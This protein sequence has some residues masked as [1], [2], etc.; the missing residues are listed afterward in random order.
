MTYINLSGYAFI[1]LN[2]LEDLK[3]RLKTYCRNLGLK[4]TILLSQEGIN[5]FI[6]G[7]REIVETFNNSLAEFQ[8]P[9]LH[10]KESPSDALPFKRMLVKIKSEIITMGVDHIDPEQHPAPYISPET[11]KE[12]YETGKAFIILDTR[13]DYEVKCG[14]FKNAVDFNITQFTDFPR[15]CETLPPEWK[16]KPIVTYCTGGIRCEK[17]APF[18]QSIGY[19]NVYQLEGGIL[20]YFERCQNDHYDGECFVFDKRIAVGSD[21]NESTTV[22]CFQCRMPVTKAEQNS[23]DYKVGEFC[24]SCVKSD[25]ACL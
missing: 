1:K 22:Q 24:P 10:F 23:P 11:L 15:A 18:L 20:N 14:K 2:N 8:L 3:G 4:G 19:E 16:D 6:A 9:R 25:K 21:L 7:T 5:V 13:N 12:W 17:A